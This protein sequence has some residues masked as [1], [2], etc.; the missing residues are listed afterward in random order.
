MR[1]FDE[2]AAPL[3]ERCR[4][5]FR[6]IIPES[7]MRQAIAVKRLPLAR[8]EAFGLEHLQ[9]LHR[10]TLRVANHLRAQLDARHFIDHAQPVKPLIKDVILRSRETQRLIIAQR[11][12]D[13]LDADAAMGKALRFAG[14]LH[15]LDTDA[16]GVRA[17]E[18][19]RVVPGEIGARLFIDGSAR[20]P[21]PRRPN[22]DVV[23]VKGDVHQPIL[24]RRSLLSRPG[25]GRREKLEQFDHR[26]VRPLEHHRP[27]PH[28]RQ[29]HGLLHVRAFNDAMVLIRLKAQCVLIETGRRFDVAHANAAM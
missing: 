2:I 9:Q 15:Q 1:L 14:C 27:Q 16:I 6:L 25:R 18:H 13:I 21:D 3:A 29:L 17:V 24:Q 5:L 26:P 23:H 8:S 11:N 10:V 28:A 4:S 7:Q 12:V 19:R 22:I 20:G